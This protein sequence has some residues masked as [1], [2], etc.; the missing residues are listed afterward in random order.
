MSMFLKKKKGSSRLYLFYLIFGIFR[1]WQRRR[2]EFYRWGMCRPDFGKKTRDIDVSAELRSLLPDLLRFAS[3]I[4]EIEKTKTIK[5]AGEILNNRFEI[6]AENGIAINPLDWH[7]DMAT[8]FTWPKGKYYT[9]YIQVDLTNNAD[10]KY[11]RELSRCHFLLYLGQ[12]YLLSNDECYARKYVEIMESWLRE[13]PFMHSI[14]WG[15]AMDVAIRAINWAYAFAMVADAKCVSDKFK[16]EIGKSF[17]Q[18]AWFVYKN[19]ESNYTN[20]ANH[21]DSNIAAMLFF[22]MLFKKTREGREWADHAREEFYFELRQ[23]VLPSGVVYEKSINYGRLVAEIFT[24]CYCLLQNVHEAIPLDIHVRI[25]KQ[26]D[27]IASYIKSDGLAPVIG[28]Q[29]DARWL[30]FSPVGNLDHKHLLSLAALL[31][32][33]SDFKVLANGYSADAFFLIKDKSKDDFQSIADVSTT[34][35]SAAFKDA[36]FFIMKTETIYIFINNGGISKYQENAGSEYYG[37]HT[38]ADLLSFELAYKTRSFLVDPGSYVYTSNPQDRNLFRSTAMHNTLRVDKMN[39]L[40]I[41]ENELFGYYANIHPK[42]GAWISN[43]EYDLFSGEHDGY[44]RLTDPVIHH[45]KIHL[46]KLSEEIIIT[47]QLSGKKI[48]DV[49]I[50]FHFAVGVDFK[51]VDKNNVVTCLDNEP[52]LAMFFDHDTDFTLEKLESWVSK[53]YGHKERSKSLKIVFSGRQLPFV[54]NTLIRFNTE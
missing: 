50:F 25:E 13:N 2:N 44:A 35:Q 19:Q 33:R 9:D 15:C 31:F 16:K 41:K 21:Y 24:F 26:F 32:N 18:H 3:E 46:N 1:K 51:I 5:K 20:N 22:G 40:V 28:D 54:F 49:E 27:F 38:H 52:N 42:L 34:R 43:T 4:S 53:K 29:D 12:A 47:D 39:Q 48:H 10:V 36:G 6:F 11:P 14:N 7:K 30:P 45:R 37:S 17:Y 23:Q 8:G